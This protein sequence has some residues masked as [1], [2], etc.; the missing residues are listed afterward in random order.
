MP[1]CL[2]LG[3]QL[4]AGLLGELPLDL[5][6]LIDLVGDLG[7]IPVHDRTVHALELHVEIRGIIL[8]HKRDEG[9]LPRKQRTTAVGEQRGVIR[10]IALV[11]EA[12][13]E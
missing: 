9:R 11:D 7:G 5:V 13:R 3:A 6:G 1:V 8:L 12:S 4:I 2:A 10:G